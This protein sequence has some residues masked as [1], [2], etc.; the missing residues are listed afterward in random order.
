MNEIQREKQALRDAM[1]GVLRLLT[2][3]ER[4]DRSASVCATLLGAPRLTEAGVVMI[5]LPLADEVDIRPFAS[6]CLAR[7]QRLCAPRTDW[8]AG[9]MH[10]VEV[11]DIEADTRAGRFGVRE[12]AGQVAIPDARIDAVVVPGLAFDTFGG[13]LGRGGGFYD[14]FLQRVAAQGRV[15][16]CAAAFDAQMVDRVPREQTDAILDA[17]ACESLL[18]VVD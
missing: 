10:A 14:R 1:K 3:R 6:A 11:R 16:S 17:V 9:D 18:I 8:D 15:W 5:Y 13:R 4:E 7:G 2:P 12:P